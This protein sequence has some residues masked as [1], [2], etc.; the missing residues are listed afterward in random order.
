M[1]FFSILLLLVA[2]C[3]MNSDK[4]IYHDEFLREKY[5][6]AKTAVERV[7]LF[8]LSTHLPDHSFNRVLFL[9]TLVSVGI[10]NRPTFIGFAFPPIFFWLHRGLG[11]KVVGFKDFHCRIFVFILCS[12]PT[13][14][15]LIVIDSGYYGYITMADIESLSITW[16]NWVVTPL[17]FLRY[18][19]D[20][21]NLTQHGLHPRWL[22]LAVNIPLLFN[23]LG[24]LAVFN[25]LR[26]LYRFIRGQYSKLPRIQSI[27]GLMTFSL[28]TPVALLSLFPHQEARFIIPILL[29]LVYLFGNS[30]FTNE[31]DG[32]CRRK[33]KNFLRYSWY[34]LNILLT[35]F[36]GF[37][38]QGGIYP[39]AT[40]LQS[41][42]KASYGVHTHVITTHSY[43]IPTFLLQLESTS[44]IW[45]DKKTGNKYR[46]APS[47][48]LYKYGSM[49]M[50]DL[51]TKVDEVL[52]DAEMLLHKYKKQY[53]FYIASPCSLERQIMETANKYYYFELV[54]EFSYYP[55]FCT[56]AL[57]SY[58]S[59]RDQFCIENNLVKKNES[60][61]IELNVFQRIS[62][63]L[64]KFC[65]NIYRV[66]PISKTTM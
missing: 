65:L 30:L 2:E 16:D 14:L 10:F 47:T 18:N 52:T 45:K 32:T 36:F 15:L 57:P 59:S 8:K 1:L 4:I 26:H 50:D 24:L 61:Q 11:S 6:V 51:F 64:K 27:T 46:L 35:M 31:S 22:H 29:P 66:K 60:R 7:K 43:S 48:F 56:E 54:E 28:T 63:Y 17:N 40:S 12:I 53:R 62:C 9:S 41:E 34:I 44:K 13:V 39:F 58:P 38:H 5:L 37:V 55:H 25:L 23:V 33:L 21:R 19:S 20:K 49:A 3:M 42:I